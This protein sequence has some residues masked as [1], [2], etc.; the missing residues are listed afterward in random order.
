MAVRSTLENRS[1]QGYPKLMKRPRTGT[2]V[3]FTALNTGF[4]VGGDSTQED[5]GHFSRNWNCGMFEEFTG[6][7]ILQNEG[8]V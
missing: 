2:V 5:I 4:V 8:G 3:L 7:V 6:K 1:E